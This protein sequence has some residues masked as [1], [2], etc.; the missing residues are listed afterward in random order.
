MFI[1]RCA[2]DKFISKSGGI[3]L[4]N[5]PIKLH[6]NQKNYQLH[7]GLQRKYWE[8]T[9]F[10]LWMESDMEQGVKLVNRTKSNNRKIKYSKY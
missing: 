5:H 9:D 4:S 7:Q 3:M 1:C 6:H 8:V 2:K 10:Q